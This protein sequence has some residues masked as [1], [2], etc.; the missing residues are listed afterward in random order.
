MSSETGG[1]SVVVASGKSTLTQA[2]GSVAPSRTDATK[3]T[4]TKSA[5]AKMVPCLMSIWVV[6]FSIL[7]RLV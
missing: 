3:S 2:L 5:G 4:G 6:G 1:A 7:A